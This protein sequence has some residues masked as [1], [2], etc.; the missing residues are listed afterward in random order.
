LQKLSFSFI[1]PVYNRPQEVEDLL[2]S[3]TLQDYKSNFE[4]VIVE[5]GSSLKADKVVKKYQKK[6]NLKY[7]FKENS[8]PGLSRNFGMQQ[9]TGNYFIILDSDVILPS[10]YVSAV[11]EILKN[12]Y[13]DAFG[14]ADTA[15]PSFTDI[16]KAINYSMTSVLTTGGL[17][18]HKKNTHFQP[19]SFNM[20]LSKKAF[21]VTGGF[22][23]QRIGED[24]DLT[25]RLWQSDFKTQFI[26]S[27]FV[28]HKRR[29]NFEQFFNQ[30]YSFGCA[31]PI[32]SKQHKKTAKFTYWFP[33][34]FVLGFVLSIFIFPFFQILT[35]LY[36]LYFLLIFMHSSI[37]NK[38]VLV[39]FLSIYTTLIQLFGYGLGFL[40]SQFNL[41]ILGKSLQETFPKMFV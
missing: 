25:F 4:V 5:D 11:A 18:G 23:A 27:A 37:L 20:G 40:Q 39:A 14:G 15:H 9:A 7:F 1:I 12:N 32:L 17:R 21:E 33:S 34:L 24:I 28:Y 3:L 35:A 6:L 38:N 10:F 13:T 26:E 2:K 29:A 19:R 22:K 30:T 41:N 36:L 16:Q 8:G 31:R